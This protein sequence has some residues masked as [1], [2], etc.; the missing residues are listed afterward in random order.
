[1]PENDTHSALDLP[2]S[3]LSSPDP[4][5]LIIPDL[6]SPRQVHVIC[7]PTACGKAV[8]ALHL[9]DAL[10]RQE[11][12]LGHRAPSPAPASCFVAC[13][14]TLAY[15]RAQMHN[16]DIDPAILP[17]V[18]LATHRAEDRSIAAALKAARARVPALR[19]LA[20]DGLASLCPGRII[21]DRDVSQFLIDA[22][23]L[24]ARE[25][26]TI[27]GTLRS[28]KTRRGEGYDYPLDRIIGAGAW[29]GTTATKIILEFDARQPDA[30]TALVYHP[31][32]AMSRHYF[33]FAEEH[34]VELSGPVMDNGP[35]DAWLDVQPHGLINYPAAISAIT[36]LGVAKRTFF[37]WLKQKVELGLVIKLGKGK[38]LI[39]DKRKN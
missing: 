15:A 1:M 35:L 24:C 16:A 4:A 37:R 22:A 32:R 33:L 10:S 2:S 14:R 21:D 39:P 29:A 30:R 13:D 9:L 19:L 11:T 7:G 25:D 20:L 8:F 6:F 18:S 36:R 27:L 3:S 17:H 38:Y 26:V 34:L 12:F 23:N 28:A 31:F 5:P